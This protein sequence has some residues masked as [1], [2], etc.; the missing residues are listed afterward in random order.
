MSEENKIQ[1]L[2]SRIINVPL[3]EYENN[4]TFIVNGRKFKTSRIIADI[5]S[6]KICHNHLIDELL[7]EFVINT[8]YEGDFSHI[9]QLI[10]FKENNIIDDELP[11][12]SEVLEILNNESIKCIQTNNTIEITNDNVFSL[13]HEHEKYPFF[14]SEKISK[15]VEFIASHFYEIYKTHKNEL[16]QLTNELLL[17]IVSN[18]RLQ[19]YSEDQLLDFINECYILDT[20][21]YNLYEYV[22]F[23]NASSDSIKKFILNFNYNDMTH[24]IWQKISY[25]LQQEI[26]DLKSEEELGIDI[27][28]RYREISFPFSIENEFSGIIKYLRNQSNDQI[29]QVVKITSSSIYNDDTNYKPSNVVFFDDQNSFFCTKNEK[30]SWICF[31]FK[32]NSII[33]THYSIKSVKWKQSDTY[34][35]SWVIQGSNDNESWMNLDEEKNSSEL[36]H[37]LAVHTFKNNMIRNRMFKYIRILSTGPDWL[38]S[39]FLGL[40]SFEIYGKLI[41]E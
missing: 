40:N 7:D 24:S 9:L 39:N 13:I 35:K 6:P 1:L 23:I 26:P 16:L 29:D 4:F 12:I 20:S 19:I 32:N 41:I 10:D 25:R 2:P 21:N 18:S 8:R 11:F 28:S 36:N 22:Y 17:K 31:E 5:L 3:Q 14:Y 37:P 30:N 38:G 33:P 15:E 34:P 27:N